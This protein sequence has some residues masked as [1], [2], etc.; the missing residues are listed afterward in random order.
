MSMVALNFLLNLILIPT[1]GLMG[2]A[3]ATAVSIATINGLKLV[4]VYMLFGLRAHNLKYLKGV[5]AIGGAGLIG[6]LVRSWLS[7]VGYSP[8]TIIPLG[9]IAFLI[10][11]TLGLWLLGLEHE[12]KM[13]IIALWRRR[14]DIPV[15][16]AGPA[17]GASDMADGL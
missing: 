14:A 17:R 6:Y 3:I 8:F 10:T 9:G 11:A 1:M 13:A 5:F 16:P 2:A 7:N 15:L 12:D 4:Q